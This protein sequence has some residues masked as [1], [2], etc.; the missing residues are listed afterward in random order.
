MT[1]NDLHST[2]SPFNLNGK[3]IIVTGASSGIGRQCAITCSH[4][5]A[6]VALFGRD[7]DRL[8]ETLSMMAEPHSHFVSSVD[9][10]DYSRVDEIIGNLVDHR[11]RINGLINCAG[12]STTLPV[13]GISIEKLEHFLKTNVISAINLTKQ[14]V[15]STRF[16][17]EGGS[18]IFMA[19]VMGV[20][21]EVGKTLYS[22]TKGAVVAAAKS[23]AI[24]LAPRKIRVNAVS[25]G[26]V[27]TPMSQKS[28]YSRNVDSLKLIKSLHPLGLGHPDD[29]A[30]SCVF[31]L[32]DAARWITGTNLIVDG[33]YLA[34]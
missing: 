26:V 22:L 8:K 7:Q 21:G 14:A 34:R 11:G 33:G 1:M 13:N 6:S 20:T 9:L 23:M 19:S 10:L 16:S 2:F 32:S 15:K 30:K 17:K 24:E 12:I 3:L 18:I 27:E 29:I 4:M 25:P 5:G 31:L 28:V